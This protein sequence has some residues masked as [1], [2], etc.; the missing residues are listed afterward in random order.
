MSSSAPYPGYLSQHPT[1]Y[2]ADP[3]HPNI[4]PSTA[5]SILL[6]ILIVAL[7]LILNKPRLPLD[8]P[9]L[10]VSLESTPPSTKSRAT[11]PKERSNQQ[12]APAK[13]LTLPKRQIVSTPDNTESESPQNT[14]RLAERDFSAERE[15]IRRGDGGS[16]TIGSNGGQPTEIAPKKSSEMVTNAATKQTIAS[17][18]PDRTPS[19]PAAKQPSASKSPKNETRNNP[20]RVSASG[21]TI[22][23]SLIP[24]APQA[25][26]SSR[27]ATARDT[28]PKQLALSLDSGTLRKKFASSNDNRSS[29]APSSSNPLNPAAGGYRA[30]SRPMGSGASFI[31]NGGTTDFLPNLPDGDLTLLNAKANKF[32]VFVRRVAVRVFSQL[33]R[34]GWESLSYGDIARAGHPA[35]VEAVLSRNGKLLKVIMRG[36]SGNPR[37]DDI[38]RQAVEAGASDPNPDV[39]AAA[40]DGNIH[41]IFSAQTWAQAATNPRTGAPTERRWL[42]LATGLQ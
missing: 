2:S 21:E 1:Q 20:S 36:T 15:T 10:T 34:S 13:T 22:P 28:K 41:F 38:L 17:S 9:V 37:Y 42:L 31:G 25:D 24:I 14:T 8:V 6:H 26:I 19:S 29:P 27:S 23:E 40:D 5:I 7:L 33:R 39:A 35:L 18:T 30:F 32:A 3:P 11:L 12:Q 16:P 4:I